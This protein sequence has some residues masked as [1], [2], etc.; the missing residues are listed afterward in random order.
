ML[1]LQMWGT[2]TT[3]PKHTTAVICFRVYDQ[4]CGRITLDRNNSDKE[5]ESLS[6]VI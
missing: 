4:G 6:C 3:Q 5:S 2:L 1:V